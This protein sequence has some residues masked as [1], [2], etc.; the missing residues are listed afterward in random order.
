[1]V[2]IIG[3]LS[4]ID[5]QLLRNFAPKAILNG[6]DFMIL[7]GPVHGAIYHTIT[8]AGLSASRIVKAIDLTLYQ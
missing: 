6:I 4:Q 2:Q 8:K 7:H 5:A 1:M 3:R